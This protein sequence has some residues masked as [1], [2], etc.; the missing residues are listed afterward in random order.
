MPVVKRV[1]RWAGAGPRAALTAAIVALP[2]DRALH[3]LRWGFPITS[4]PTFAPDPLL[5]WAARLL[6]RV[7]L[8]SL[9]IWNNVF[10]CWGHV[11]VWYSVV[12]YSVVS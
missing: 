3:S 7:R 4:A 1:L 8:L 2:T 12:W 10:K 5:E 11:I 9:P 6:H